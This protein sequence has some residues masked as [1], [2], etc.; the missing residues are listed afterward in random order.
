MCQT[1]HLK[2]SVTLVIEN[3]LGGIPLGVIAVETRTVELTVPADPANLDS[4][5][6]VS[7]SHSMFMILPDFNSVS[8]P[9]TVLCFDVRFCSRLAR[10]GFQ[11]QPLKLHKQSVTSTVSVC[12]SW[13]LPTGGASP[14]E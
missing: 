8:P 12:P 11:I 9:L 13:C 1:M 5:S 6:K 10:S 4:E 7:K 14:V 3:R 2:W